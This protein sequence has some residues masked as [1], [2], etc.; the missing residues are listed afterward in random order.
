M[1]QE[2]AF[3]QNLHACTCQLGR[4]ASAIPKEGERVRVALLKDLQSWQGNKR[5]TIPAGTT[6]EGTASRVD[7][8]GFFDIV[9]DKGQCAKFYIHDS[10]FQVAVIS[11]V[12]AG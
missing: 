12:P 3:E 11:S 8:E 10:S 6:Y 7:D 2:H 1:A 4:G 5:I 9:D